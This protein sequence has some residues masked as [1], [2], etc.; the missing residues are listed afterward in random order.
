MTYHRWMRR[1]GAFLSASLMLL[2]A[3]CSTD[4]VVTATRS[5]TTAVVSDIEVDPDTRVLT[6]DNGLV[7]YLRSN[8]RPGS[9]ASMRL[10]INAGSAM[11]GPDQSGVAHFLEHMLFN[12]TDQFPGNDL[13]DVLRGFGMEFG[14]DINAYTSYDETVYELTVPLDDTDNLGIGLDVLQQWLT[15]ATI[16]ESEVTAE[17]GVVLDEWRVRDQTLDGR[18]S[19]A[20]EGLFL[21]ETGY[22]DRQPIGTEDAIGAM[23]AEPM[24]RFYDAWY[25]PE[26]AAVVVVGDFDVDEVE[27]LVRARFDDVV[28]RGE[29]PQRPDL[30]IVPY[31]AAAA[32]VLTDPDEVKATV[33]LTY[34]V[35][36]KPT[37]TTS[38]LRSYLVNVLAFDIIANRLSDDATRGEAAFLSAASSNNDWVRGLRAPSVYVVA[39][40]DAL[41]GTIDALIGE[42]ERARR[43]GFDDNELAR[44]VDV[45]RSGLQED[46][47]GRDTRQDSDYS[48][49]FVGNF[50][51]LDQIGSAKAEFEAYTEV[52][53]AVT[54]DD[55][56]AAFAAHVERS[57]PHLFISMPQDADAVPSEADLLGLLAAAGDRE[58]KPRQETAA[59][60]TQLMEA[61]Q[62]V[63]ETDSSTVAD[64]PGFFLDATRLV[65]DNGAVVILNPTDI[66]DGEVSVIASSPGGLSLLDEDDAFAAGYA[67]RVVTTSGLGD[68]DQVAVDTILGGASVDVSPYIDIVSE[69][70]GGSTTTEDLELTFQLLHQY[71]A[72]PRF[73][74][75]ALDVEKASDQPFIEDPTTDADFAAF[76]A[77]I[78]ARYGDSPYYRLLPTQAEFDAIELADVERVYADR[79]DGAGDWVFVMSGD[80]ALSDATDL[81]RRY[82]GT[83][84]GGGSDE[85]WK[86]VEPALP[87]GVVATEVA[88]GTG[89]GGSLNLLYTADSDGS[90]R[91]PVLAAM[92]NS[93]IDTRLTDHIREE[94]GASYSPYAS[95]SVNEAPVASVETYVSV[96]GDPDGLDELAVTVH[97]DFVDLATNG[98][99][100]AEFDAALAAMEQ[101]YGYLNNPQLAMVLLAAES[102]PEAID[103]LLDEYDQLREITPE[104][105]AAFAARVLPV[106][107]YIQV[108]QRPL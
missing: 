14:A 82:I 103:A 67:V 24:R 5:D 72:A 60:G 97:E 31:T 15:A 92:L 29:M 52:L 2:A 12:G 87:A 68:L 83:L 6:L 28:G 43:Y 61:P 106:D 25:R 26:N 13:I 8:D 48:S 53:D 75:S 10:A 46:Y 99:S 73:V 90:Q 78:A 88:A 34:P 17:R 4:T 81:A 19:A 50:L 70:F 95:M 58:I 80:F 40:A 47:D 16:D 105:L 59:V 39:E 69:G 27:A 18:V 49:D 1:T 84:S 91:E 71:I 11:E 101:E 54:A 36:A 3:A 33:E 65:F 45:Y 23:T 77:L 44:A 66:S 20:L 79:F 38:A 21:S 51:E 102:D 104:E 63:R 35:P 22:D 32:V 96:S 56:A 42:F 107:R 74:Q 94:L 57:A 85:E 64:I 93:V 9:S 98:P 100:A 62:P 108:I 55:V 76:D 89:E 41:D 86:N 30:D 37:A 7:V